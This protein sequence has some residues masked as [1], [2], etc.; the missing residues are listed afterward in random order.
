MKLIRQYH[1]YGCIIACVAML[2]GL[3]YKQ[4]YSHI[5][6]HKKPKKLRGIYVRDEFFNR[7]MKLGLKVRKVKPA[8]SYKE[9]ALVAVVHPIYAYPEGF[10]GVVWSKDSERFLDPYPTPRRYMKKHLPQR[11]YIDK[12]VHAWLIYR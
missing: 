3:T 8:K 10:H 5:F 4:A 1:E 12:S 11:S 9:N 7:L 2:S 6:P